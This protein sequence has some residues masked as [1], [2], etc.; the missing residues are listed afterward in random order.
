VLA[1][2]FVALP[3]VV[4][5]A[6]RAG[7]AYFP[8]GDAASTDLMVRDVFT[9]HT[10]LIGAY[11][12]G[13]NHPGPLLFWL[14]APLAE[15]SGHASWATLVG[16][17]LLQTIGIVA[18]GVLAYRRGGVH[19]TLL[20]LA[21]LALMYVALDDLAFL[22]PWNPMIALPFFVLFLL[23]V[24]SWVDGHLWQ[25][26]GAFATG[27]LLVQF[28]FGYAPLVAS[29]IV[30]AAVVQL[31]NHR[32]TATRRVRPDDPRGVQTR[33]PSGRLVAA[34]SLLALGVLW[35]APVIEQLTTNPGNVRK[36]VG[37]VR[38]AG[39][40]LG[41]RTGAG[42]FASEFRVVPPWLGGSNRFALFAID[43]AQP[44]PLAWL[45]VP[46]ALIA[47]GLYA[48]QRSGR[49]SDRHLV[50]LASVMSG[51]SVIAMSRINV[52]PA[53]YLFLWRIPVALFL[54]GASGYAVWHWLRIGRRRML[55]HVV[56]VVLATAI[57]VGF[58]GQAIGAFRHRHTVS[59]NEA[60]VAAL[61]TRLVDLDLREPVLVRALGPTWSGL[62]QGL[63][64]ELARRHIDVRV[65][66]E[67][68]YHFG[69]QRTIEPA[70]ASTVLYLVEDTYDRMRLEAVPGARVVVRVTPLSS[71]G[72]AALDE[73]QSRIVGKL[74][75]LGIGYLAEGIDS[76]LYG[77]VLLHQE[78]A[79]AAV[80]E[81]DL[82]ALE[83]LNKRVSDSGKCR[84]GIIEIP[85]QEANDLPHTLG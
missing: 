79:S 57:V 41:L 66:P 6:T 43:V 2:H 46:T 15:V 80:G 40:P 22:N 33:Q 69:E 32:R 84:C 27:T 70:S 13:F 34:W 14:L 72:Q 67:Y 24:W 10:P 78:A 44:A 29:A 20:I 11:S 7:R 74:G 9:T 39:E 48:A 36:L 1:C 30:W 73:L 31:H 35:L 61:A 54:V 60:V 12:R 18:A 51:V 23:Q 82:K 25:M 63:I 16:G 53:Y 58:V 85:P 81:R 71:E 37:F 83:R 19:L 21:M 3:L 77:L 75:A 45:L 8:L 50:E 47:V 52:E 62:D 28:H 42:L 49:R 56:V 38:D 5:I 17:A 59:P 68:G 55:A 4:V 26:V 65:D 64:N 76:P